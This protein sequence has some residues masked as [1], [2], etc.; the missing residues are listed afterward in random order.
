MPVYAIVNDNIV[1]NVIV[2]YKNFV[3]KD[4]TYILADNNVCVGYKYENGV[5]IAPSNEIEQ[6]VDLSYE[7]IERIIEAI[8]NENKN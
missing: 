6:I 1:T 8:K 2:T 3:P 7:D 5:F 4:S